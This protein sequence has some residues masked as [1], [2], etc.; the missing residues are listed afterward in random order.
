MYRELSSH[1]LMIVGTFFFHFRSAMIP[2]AKT[3]GKVA[4][5]ISLCIIFFPFHLSVLGSV[6]VQA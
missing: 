3:I 4:G 6:A 5:R 2:M 1:F